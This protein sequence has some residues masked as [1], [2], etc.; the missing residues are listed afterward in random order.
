M[1]HLFSSHLVKFPREEWFLLNNFNP[2]RLQS[3]AIKAYPINDRP[4]GIDDIKSVNY[5]EK[6]KEI[7]PIWII[8]INNQYTLLDGTHRIVAANIK[9]KKF[10]NAYII[11]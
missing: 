6:Q 11:S 9:H 10:I 7:P 3:S 5:Y 2:S 1:A 8:K 4:R